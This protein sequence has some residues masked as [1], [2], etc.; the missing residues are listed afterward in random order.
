MQLNKEGTH[1]VD[2]DKLLRVRQLGD[3]LRAVGQSHAPWRDVYYALLTTTW[4]RFIGIMVS[5]YFAA[6]LVFAVG[7]Y[8]MRGSI[9]QADT[10]LDHFFF[11]V[12]TWATI[13][14][15]VMAPITVLSH[16][17]VVVESLCGIVFVA[18]LTGLIFSKFS[19]SDAR[20][21]FAK[22]IVVT[23]YNGVPTLMIR[24]ANE[25][26][27]RIVEAEARVAVLRDDVSAEGQQL[28]RVIDL[29][30][31]RRDTLFFRAS[32]MIMHTINESSPLHGLTEDNKAARMLRLIV[33][34]KGYDTSSGQVAH[35]NH[36]YEAEHVL[37]GHRYKDASFI[38]SDNRTL[39]DYRKIHDVEPEPTQT[40]I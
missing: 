13:G 21:A 19:L 26:G 32:W 11:S 34:I 22:S 9:S 5:A 1:A 28:R 2:G 8:A 24:V 16:W 37:L 12:Q 4:W 7:Y 36:V 30:L 35:G 18:I 33:S 31:V 10:F 27:S 14:Y 17:M 25:R 15:G 23:R 38:M 6:N 39:L 20:I 3:G 40:N 29:P